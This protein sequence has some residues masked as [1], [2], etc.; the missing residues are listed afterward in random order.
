VARALKLSGLAALFAA[1]TLLAAMVATAG[2]AQE[3]T[4]T[5]VDTTASELTT[6][7]ATTAEAT[8]AEAVTTTPAETV[9]TT[10]QST[11]TR[12]VLLPASTTTSSS[13]SD[14]GT[15]AWVWVLLAI[16]AVGLIA[17]I[18]LLATRGHGGASVEERR[19]H[20][21][22]AVG[23]WAAQGWAVES[24]GADSTVLRRGGESMLVS[25]DR[26]GHVSTRPLPPSA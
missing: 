10:V 3:T 13:E 19:R 6:A 16:L 26:S 17:V 8:T 23:T 1:G 7:E 24:E 5:A 22:A 2:H 21:D 11:T 25:V 20:L 18:V 4:T 12:V 14:E 9:V 15:P